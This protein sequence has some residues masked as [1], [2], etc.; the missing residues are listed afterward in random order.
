MKA[1][2]IKGKE[3]GGEKPQI[4]IPITSTKPSELMEELR[5]VISSNPDLIEWRV[6]YFDDVEDADKV[7][8]VL[9]DIYPL[10]TNFPLI[11]TC[12]MKEEG[13]YKQI[14]QSK[15]INLIKKVIKSQLIDF[16]DIELIN[17][18]EKIGE[19]LNEIGSSQIKL[20]LSS[21]DFE[22]TPSKDAIIERLVKAQEYGADIAKIAVMPNNQ[23]DVLTLL[24]ASLEARQ[25]HVEIP[26]ITMSMA[27]RGLVT[28]IAG[29]LFGSAISFAAGRQA[30][31]PGQIPIWELRKSM[32]IL[33]RAL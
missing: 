10:L 27:G 6:D 12:R 17:G 2:T 4:C 14:I 19:I 33:H 13:G 11:F 8:E 25:D 30:S 23:K 24:E 22:N 32:E 5:E 16:L 31:A 21:H 29:N 3:I 26:L 9:E 20:I 7:I 1:I 15:R 28:R 18:K